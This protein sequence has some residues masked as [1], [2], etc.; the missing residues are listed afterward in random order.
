MGQ[1]ATPRQNNP[2]R[3][4]AVRDVLK[5]KK[6]NMLRFPTVRASRGFICSTS[7]TWRRTGHRSPGRRTIPIHQVSR[8]WHEGLTVPQIAAAIGPVNGTKFTPGSI[9]KAIQREREAGN[10]ALFP[11]R[12]SADDGTGNGGISER[13]ARCLGL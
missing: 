9:D 2:D 13:V 11:L 6:K 5:S 8:L 7:G 10:Y 4:A 3:R 1:C 12:R